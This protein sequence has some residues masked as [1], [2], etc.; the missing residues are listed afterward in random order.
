MNY[1][2]EILLFL[3]I[4]IGIFTGKTL[5]EN[6]R[7]NKEHEDIREGRRVVQRNRNLDRDKLVNKL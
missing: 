2:K 5:S 7:L 4:L 3:G 6:K 1:I